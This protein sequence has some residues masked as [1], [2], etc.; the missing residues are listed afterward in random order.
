MLGLI[1][2]D[3]IANKK[4]FLLMLI[5]FAAFNTWPFLPALVSEDF[6]SAMRSFPAM[7]QGLFL[8]MTISSFYLTGMI[9]DGFMVQDESR[10]WAYFIA[11][12][13]DGVKRLVGSKYMLCVLLTMATGYTCILCNKM[14]FDLLGDEIP[15]LQIIIISLFYIQM[16][17]RAFSYPFIFA[18]GAK[19]GG[20]AKSVALLVIVAAG[21]TYLLFGDLSFITDH[22][23]ELWDKFFGLLTDM[24]QSWKISMALYIGCLVT[25]VIYWLSYK[26]SC[27]VYMKG[28]E[29]FEK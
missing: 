16:I 11:S 3:I 21:L 2:K 29:R 27:K 1:Y 4:T 22:S 15:D 20:S 9:E 13:E 10:K 5:G 25:P 23:D 8:L 26:L 19:I 28:V 6:S 14:A 17:C 24:T 7:F 18:F 12:T